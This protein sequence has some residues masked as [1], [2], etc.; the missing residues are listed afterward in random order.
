MA[1]GILASKKRKIPEV[2]VV[3]IDSTSDASGL[4]ED[5]VFRT[6]TLDGTLSQ[7]E[8]SDEEE[9]GNSDFETGDEL[10]SDEGDEEEEEEEVMD[11]DD[12]DDEDDEEELEALKKQAGAEKAL[13]HLS[14]ARTDTEDA[15][16]DSELED[17]PAGTRV[18]KDSNGN[19]RYVFPEIEPNY[20]S[21][22]SDAAD[23]ENTIGDIPLSLY[24]MFPHIGY[25]IDGKKIVRPAAGKALD[26]LLD[27]IDLPKGWTGMIDKNTGKPLKISK[28]ELGIVAQ[29]Q[30]QMVP[31]EGEGEY[32]PY[33]P[34]IEWFT[35]KTEI[36]PL[37]SAPEPKRRFVPSKHEA[38]RIMKIV[39]AIREGRIVPRKPEEEPLVP[40]L[41][42]LWSTPTN[43][44]ADP[45]ALPAP[46]LPPP[47]H[48]E[49]YHPP[50][51]YL[52]NAEE[53]KEWEELDP[54]D[55]P[56]DYLP[57][58]FSSLRVVPGY[59]RFVKERFERC[60]DLYLAPRVRRRRM[61]VDPNTLLP[62]LPSPQ[63]LRPFPTSCAT[64]YRGHVGRVRTL[65][66][67]P[68][69]QWLATGGDDGTV[70]LWEVLTGRE[71]WRAKIGEDGVPV[72]AV[73][74]RPSVEGGILA[75]AA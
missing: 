13:S 25:T 11:E 32:D 29:I 62:K 35:S 36:M 3:G 58:N 40:K 28:E 69:G 59:N 21:D 31:K 56:R 57:Q 5:D 14:L 34:T 20:D 19:P 60:L 73:K 55:R 45:M 26:A 41:Y 51:E 16:Y 67:D 24:D 6:G 49:S 68:R 23:A 12:S 42:D 46:K 39:R 9:E 30:R 2:S 4:E 52:P 15:N 44:K 48:A 38:K 17:L 33:E 63:D 65:A 8:D 37:S 43:A 75:A 71:V 72:S 7:D 74:W 54:E 47:T 10:S 50:L 27:T 1:G 61:F 70:R 18:E 66:V 53:K 64:L 22:D